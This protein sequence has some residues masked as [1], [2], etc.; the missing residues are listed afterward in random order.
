MHIP[1]TVFYIT[2]RKN[3]GVILTREDIFHKRISPP[4][5][6]KKKDDPSVPLQQCANRCLPPLR[7]CHNFKLS[8]FSSTLLF[9]TALPNF[10]LKLPKSDL[11]FASADLPMA[12]HK[13]AC[14]NLQFFCYSRI[15]LFC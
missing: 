5:F 10:L 3:D 12:H 2:I 8:F 13:F 1:L 7:N 15:N 14:A 9:K 6:K 11:P 4:A